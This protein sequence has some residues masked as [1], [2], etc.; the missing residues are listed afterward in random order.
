M[1]AMGNIM[2]IAMLVA[3]PAL[4]GTLK[5]NCNGGGT[6]TKA[7]E[8]AKVGDTIQVTGTCKERVTI[9]TDRLTLD[10]QGSAILDGGGGFKANAVREGV[11]TIDGAS[12]VTVTGFTL[13]RGPA[14][15]TCKRGA[16]CLMRNTTMQDNAAEG[17][18]VSENSTAE[19]TGCISRRN[20][21]WGIAVFDNS[22]VLLQGTIALTN[23]GTSGL[24]VFFSSSARS[25]KAT[26]QANNNKHNGIILG[27]GSNVN[28]GRRGGKVTTNNNMGNGIRLFNSGSL[29]VYAG[30]TVNV[31][32][33]SG[34]GVSVDGNSS[35]QNFG[36]TFVIKNNKGGGLLVDNGGS[37]TMKGSTITENG[38]DVALSFGARATLNGNTIGTIVCDNISLIRGDTACPK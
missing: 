29:Q 22:N 7:L 2:V 25:S 30:N 32:G 37:V 20:G 24:G 14:G 15:I 10:G 13:Q 6:I 8:T 19:V 3:S 18:R 12:G 38:T 23:N 31:V 1:K 26:I 5:V 28:F 35:L 16:A 27:G 36:G 33:N 9:T 4:A 21:E 34:R 17:L 11:V